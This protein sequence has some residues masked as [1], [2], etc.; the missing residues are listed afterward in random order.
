MQRFGHVSLPFLGHV[1]ASRWSSNQGLG[2]D[3]D[4][5]TGTTLWIGRWEVNADTPVSVALPVLAP[6][7]ML[8]AFMPRFMG[9]RA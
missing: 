2:L 7:A 6:L 5:K 9:G 3:I 4:R 1:T 8:M